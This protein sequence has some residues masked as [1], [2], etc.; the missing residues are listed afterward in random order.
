MG[1]VHS[2]GEIRI[3]KSKKHRALA[4][5]YGSSIRISRHDYKILFVD[6]IWFMNVSQAGLCDIENKIL[7]ITVKE[8]IEA[9]LLHEIFHAECHESGIRQNPRWD[10]DNT[11]EPLVEI[12]SQS[13][14]HHFKL[15]KR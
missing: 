9:T 3:K 12:M 15:S 7:Y 5:K 6:E 1:N 10:V 14:A 4:K 2:D 11:E 8:E 13:I